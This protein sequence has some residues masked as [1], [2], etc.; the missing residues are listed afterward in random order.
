M[1]CFSVLNGDYLGSQ[2]ID[3]ERY[4]FPHIG[5]DQEIEGVTFWAN[6]HSDDGAISSIHTMVLNI[7]QLQGDAIYFKHYKVADW[8]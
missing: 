5:P 7:S 6:F 4:S 3:K 8:A 1:R 2:H